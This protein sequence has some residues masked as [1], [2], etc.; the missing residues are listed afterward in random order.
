MAIPSL[1]PLV[2]PPT[3]ATP[4]SEWPDAADE[5]V[6]DQYR[7][8]VDFNDMTIPALNAAVDDVNAAA[9]EVEAAR[10]EV[11]INAATVQT[12]TNTV[13]TLAGEVSADAAQAS[14]DAIQVAEDAQAVADALASIAG[15][16]VASVAGITGVV[17]AEQLNAA[18]RAR[19]QARILSFM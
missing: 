17:T 3:Q 2:I 4:E 16:P 7:W 10:A 6:T 11:A 19:T 9:P 13:V 18:I 12:N 14:A 15:G 1:T 8:S 5:F